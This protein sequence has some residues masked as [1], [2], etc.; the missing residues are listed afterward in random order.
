MSKKLSAIALRRP[1]ILTAVVCVFLIAGNRIAST[2]IFGQPGYLA[3]CVLSAVVLVGFVLFS[4]AISA[5]Q[6]GRRFDASVTAEAIDS[7]VSL[8]TGAIL[9]LTISPSAEWLMFGGILGFAIALLFSRI[10]ASRVLV[11]RPAKRTGEY[12]VNEFAHSLPVEE[13]KRFSAWMTLAA[14]SYI[15]VNWGLLNKWILGRQVSM[16]DAGRLYVVLTVC[17]VPFL[18]FQLAGTVMQP[19]LSEM[20]HRGESDL[21]RSSACTIMAWGIPTCLGVCVVIFVLVCVFLTGLLGADYK[22]PLSVIGFLALSCYF[23]VVLYL[24]SILAIAEGRARTVF[25]GNTVSAVTN[26]ILC[27]LLVNGWGMRGVALALTVAF[28]AGAAAISVLNYLRKV[29]F[30]RGYWAFIVLPGV[31]MMFLTRAM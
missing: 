9:A 26:A 27:L 28:F 18:F 6:G 21:V 23:H 25:V 1:L 8:L 14:V 13:V 2:L 30:F 17:W 11:H 10:V 15:F 24:N 4:L 22:V 12:Q 16:G 29:R 20:Y 5:F 3:L 19:R 7:G 31:L